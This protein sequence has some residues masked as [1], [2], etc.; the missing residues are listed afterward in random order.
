MRWRLD[1]SYDGGDFRGWAT[2]PGL[3][4]V[5]ETLEEALTTVLRLPETARLTCAGRTDAGV[6]ARGQVAHVDLDGLEVQ[7]DPEKLLRRLGRRLPADVRVR[8]VRPAAPGF[9]ARFSALRRRYV[10]RICDDTVGPDPLARGHVVHYRHRLDVDAMVAASAH[11][12]GEHDFASFCRR[13]EGATTVRTLLR[14]DPVRRPDGTI[15]ATVAADAF[16]HSMVRSLMGVVVAVGE[17]RFAPSWA[18]EVLDARAR[19][20]QVTV[21]PAHGLTL[22]EVVYPSDDELASRAHQTRRRRDEPQD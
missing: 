2:Q 17:G 10:Y 9:D 7:P 20:S 12:L 13:R 4:T 18:T 16:C 19:L 21:M 6:H 11:L 3:R 14:L 8:A 22:E 1:V 15:E 5:Q